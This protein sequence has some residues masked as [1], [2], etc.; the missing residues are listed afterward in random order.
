MRQKVLRHTRT[1]IGD[2]QHDRLGLLR[3]F[4]IHR[5]PHGDRREAISEQVVGEPPEILRADRKA[6]SGVDGGDGRNGEADLCTVC[7]PDHACPIDTAHELRDEVVGGTRASGHRLPSEPRELEQ[8]GCER[9]QP[10]HRLLG[11]D[12]LGSEG[13]GV[14][15]VI[16]CELE[17]GLEGGQW[18]AKFMSGI[19]HDLLFAR[20]RGTDARKKRVER[21]RQ[22]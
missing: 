3:Q 7:E 1:G 8:V 11:G 19:R 4:G 15:E 17:L 5:S 13:V 6:R 2:P 22:L 14:I 16:V 20:A 10:G 12:N 18:G 9:G 21:R